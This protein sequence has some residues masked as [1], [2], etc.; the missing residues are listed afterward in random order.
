MSLLL[1]STGLDSRTP[2]TIE[3]EGDDD[4]IRDRGTKDHRR[5]HPTALNE[6][7]HPLG[8]L[9]RGQAQTL[10]TRVEKALA[11]YSAAHSDVQRIVA[12]NAIINCVGTQSSQLSLYGG[13]GGSTD[14]TNPGNPRGQ[15]VSKAADALRTRAR[16]ELK[17]IKES[18]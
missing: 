1:M 16:K 3:G 18:R 9:G 7:H 5:A 13:A 8:G 12:L 10:M 4:R 14:R 15:A 6:Y 17:R 11:S 2:S